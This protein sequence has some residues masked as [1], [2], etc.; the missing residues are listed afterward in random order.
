MTIAPTRVQ[1]KRT[2]ALLIA[3]AAAVPA[4]GARGDISL[5]GRLSLPNAVFVSDVWGFESGG[6]EYAVVG[7]WFGDKVFIVDATDPAP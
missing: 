7:D 5:A 6:R 2:L 1:V 4:H 3:L